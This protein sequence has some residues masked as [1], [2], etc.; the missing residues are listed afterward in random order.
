MDRR[1]VICTASCQSFFTYFCLK[2]I[3]KR[4]TALW[5]NAYINVF[6]HQRYINPVV[7][8]QNININLIIPFTG[9]KSETNVKS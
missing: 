5:K 9:I 2:S 6:V 1:D 7:F 4:L 3:L 8:L